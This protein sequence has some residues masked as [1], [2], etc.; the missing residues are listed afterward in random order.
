MDTSRGIQGIKRS[1]DVIGA[2]VV[3]LVAMPI[4][5]LAVLCVRIIS[6][7]PVLFRQTRTGLRQNRFAMYKLRTMVVDSEAR[8]TAH[9]ETHPADRE[10]WVRYRR[11]RND[12]RIIPYVGGPIRRLSIDEL[13]QLWNVIRGDMSLV[14]PRPL[15]VEVA[16]GFEPNRLERRSRVRPGMTGLWQVSGRSETDLHRMIELDDE[17]V[18]HW[19][20]AMDLSILAKTPLAVVSRRGA[21]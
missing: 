21:F 19:S 3:L 8:L 5:L 1:V 11:L 14:G 6:P 9:F 16:S 18:S 13:P 20:V 7:G 4:L 10:E 2:A 12:P 17:Y 15:E